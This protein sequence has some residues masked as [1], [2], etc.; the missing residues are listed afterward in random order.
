MRNRLTSEIIKKDNFTAGG[1]VNK[2][3]IL[4]NIFFVMLLN[5]TET[6]REWPKHNPVGRITYVRD[7]YNWYKSYTLVLYASNRT[8]RATNKDADLTKFNRLQ[9]MYKGKIEVRD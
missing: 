6:T 4:L 8:V 5:A 7:D 2:L 1:F 3:F 9:D